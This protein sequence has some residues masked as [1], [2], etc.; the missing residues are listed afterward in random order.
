MAGG[1][2][3]LS[4]VG[5]PMAVASFATFIITILMQMQLG[6]L[7]DGDPTPTAQNDDQC[8]VIVAKDRRGEALSDDEQVIF[9][10]DWC[11]QHMVAV[12][13]QV[14]ADQQ[15]RLTEAQ[16]DVQEAQP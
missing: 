6:C 13:A 3:G 9:D 15:V 14:A 7:G 4:F 12:D 2:K 8:E 16:Q 10:K 1:Q 5:E 11:V